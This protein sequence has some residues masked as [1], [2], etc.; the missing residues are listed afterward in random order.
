[1]AEV[2]GKGG[3]VGGQEGGEGEVGWGEEGGNGQR[4]AQHCLR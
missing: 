2:E 3:E 4:G 1:M